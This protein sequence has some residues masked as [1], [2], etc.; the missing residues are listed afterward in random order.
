MNL[1]QLQMLLIK[2]H[3]IKQKV[4]L[5]QMAYLVVNLEK[6]HCN[7]AYILNKLNVAKDLLKASRSQSKVNTLTELM[8]EIFDMPDLGDEVEKKHSILIREA[9]DIANVIYAKLSLAALEHNFKTSV[10]WKYLKKKR[11]N[12][13]GSKNKPIRYNNQRQGRAAFTPSNNHKSG[14]MIEDEI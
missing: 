14:Q 5:Q 6:M 3:Q 4:N 11:R 2:D 9:Q 7:N 8:T 12:N 10:K 1:E 13:F